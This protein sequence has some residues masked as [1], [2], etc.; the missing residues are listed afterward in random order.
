M[1]P[2]LLTHRSPTPSEAGAAHRTTFPGSQVLVGCW[3]A[4]MEPNSLNLTPADK[5]E[6]SKVTD[7]SPKG[8]EAA[9]TE[10]FVSVPE[11]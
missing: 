10:T 7:V 11:P 9:Y 1:P 8:Q 2:Q 4:C 6:P 3:L 5:G